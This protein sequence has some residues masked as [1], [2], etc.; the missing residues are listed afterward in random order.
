M[1]SEN[2]DWPI[3]AGREK[4]FQQPNSPTTVTEQ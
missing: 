4:S 3:P 2:D 1:A